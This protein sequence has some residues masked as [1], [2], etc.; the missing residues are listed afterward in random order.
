MA[1]KQVTRFRVQG[2]T[3]YKHKRWYNTMV[4]S[5]K[6]HMTGAGLNRGLTREVTTPELKMADRQKLL[7]YRTHQEVNNHVKWGRWRQNNKTGDYVQQGDSKNSYF[8]AD[9]DTPA[10]S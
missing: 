5:D 8:R 3:E 2:G 7:N 9:R 6:E 10:P 4:G 1:G